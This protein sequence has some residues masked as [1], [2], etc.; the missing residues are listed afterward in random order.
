MVS[1]GLPDPIG[2]EFAETFAE[3]NYGVPVSV[4]IENLAKRVDCRDLFFLALSV[5]IQ[6]DTG[7]NLAETLEKTAYV[8][9]ERFK[10]FGKVKALA[11]EGI[12]SAWIL[13]L[14]PF[15][16][17]FILYL[18]NRDYVLMLINDPLG[19]TISLLALFWL[20]LGILV[21]RHI[22]KIKV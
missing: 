9:R 14:L 12:Y 18:L 3:I 20:S 7:G 2:S 15:I 10:L 13:G 6:R 16:M 11:A 5:G 22:V 8:I 17:A 19:K 1:R 21:I 4:A